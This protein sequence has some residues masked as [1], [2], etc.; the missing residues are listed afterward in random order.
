MSISDNWPDPNITLENYEDEYRMGLRSFV[1]S[2]NLGSLAKY[3]SNLH[4]NKLPCRISSQKFQFG[5]TFVVFEVQFDDISWILRIMQPPSLL[6]QSADAALKKMRSEVITLKYISSQTS[7]PVPKI[8]A[9]HFSHSDTDGLEDQ[10]PPF[11][12]ETALPGRC[13]SDLG[14]IMTDGSI[15]FDS[16]SSGQKLVVQNYHHDLAK[17]HISLSSLT[18]PTIGSLSPDESGNTIVVANPEYREGP[19]KTP[20]EYFLFLADKL[21]QLALV[22][23]DLEERPKRLFTAMAWRRAVASLLEAEASEA[24]FPLW[25]GDLHH[26]NILV[27]EAGHITGVLDWDCAAVVPWEQFG[28]P[29]FQLGHF[30]TSQPKNQVIGFNVSVFSHELTKA[31]PP[32]EKT[33][34]RL[35]SAWHKSEIATVAS[36]LGYFMSTMECDYDCV[37][38]SIYNTMGW[39]SI[40]VAYDAYMQSQLT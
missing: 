13:I 40:D 5:Q 15:T 23:E 1:N 8:L 37:G 36:F 9:A 4:P 26:E 3:A 11:M 24:P 20:K 39:G 30:W 28:I 32:K 19:F 6:L 35:L 16:L 31:E 27:D 17:F 18:F 12:L 38:R 21:E 7:I 22:Y 2:L 25:H 33:A 14:I 10:F 34:G 29:S